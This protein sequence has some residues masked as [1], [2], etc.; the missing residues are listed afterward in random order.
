MIK[1]IWVI[2]ALDCDVNK[3]GLKNVVKTIHWRLLGVNDNNISAELFGAQTIGE[4]NK[5]N[6]KAFDDLEKQDIIDWL[7]AVMDVSTLE[8][9][10]AQ[11]IELIE[12]PTT[13]TLQLKKNNN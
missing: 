2:S 12:N 1:F 8:E 7:N 5:D 4:P 11:K 3:E 10:I 9:N 6:F 13:V